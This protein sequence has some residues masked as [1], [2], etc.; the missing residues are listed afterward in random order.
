MYVNIATFEKYD[1][2]NVP[3]DGFFTSLCICSEQHQSFS[4][5]THFP[6][7]P[8]GVSYCDDQGKIFTWEYF[9]N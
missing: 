5:Q 2:I 8:L 4:T 7:D 3:L 9:I 1:N 6:G